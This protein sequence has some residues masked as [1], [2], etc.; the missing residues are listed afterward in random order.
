MRKNSNNETFQAEFIHALTQRLSHLY[1][2]NEKRSLWVAIPRSVRDSLT[3]KLDQMTS[4]NWNHGI[5][6]CRK[7]AEV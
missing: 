6:L 5:H 3:Y 2:R 1:R 4:R 7:S